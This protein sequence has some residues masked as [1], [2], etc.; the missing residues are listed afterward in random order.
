MLWCCWVAV[1]LDFATV[2]HADKPTFWRYTGVPSTQSSGMQ[3][4]PWSSM[5][6][7]FS[8]RSITNIY[9]K[10][11]KTAKAGLESLETCHPT[12]EIPNVTAW[13]SNVGRWISYHHTH[14]AYTNP[15]HRI[16]TKTPLHDWLWNC[17]LFIC[18]GT[19]KTEHTWKNVEYMVQDTERTADFSGA[20]LTDSAS[21]RTTF[22]PTWSTGKLRI[23]TWKQ[24][25]IVPSI[26]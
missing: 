3:F 10:S 9:T 8:R 20:R 15:I 13:V 19:L 12:L 24:E 6:I 22:Q 1:A 5:I 17:S 11:S 14:T 16:C 18:M 4:P 25:P 2:L 23:V 7:S 26:F 21:H